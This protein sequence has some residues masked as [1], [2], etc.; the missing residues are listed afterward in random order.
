MIEEKELSM[1]NFINKLHLLKADKNIYLQ[2]IKNCDFMNIYDYMIE[3]V[4]NE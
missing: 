3:G 2:N 4:I 1:N